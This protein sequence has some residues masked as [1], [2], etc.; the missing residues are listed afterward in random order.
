MSHCLTCD[1]LKDRAYLRLIHKKLNSVLSGRSCADCGETN[2]LVLEFDSGDAVWKA[3]A[4]QT[5]WVKINQIISQSTS[6]CA[7]CNRLRTAEAVGPFGIPD[8]D[9]R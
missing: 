1:E 6:V 8:P 9:R 4:A 2:V 3:I 5:P 7:N